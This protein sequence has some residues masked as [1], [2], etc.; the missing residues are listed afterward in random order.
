MK[1]EDGSAEG[2]GGREREAEP[3]GETQTTPAV[4]NIMAEDIEGV[5]G[6]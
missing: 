5:S 4:F 3:D 6:A 2:S 1:R